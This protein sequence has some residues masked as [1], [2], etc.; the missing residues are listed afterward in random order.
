MGR[1]TLTFL[2]HEKIIENVR[3][4]VKHALKGRKVNILNKT[5]GGNIFCRK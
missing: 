5:D 1:K 4:Q 3:K 2:G